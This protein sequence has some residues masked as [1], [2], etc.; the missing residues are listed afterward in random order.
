ML[1]YNGSDR[2]KGSVSSSKGNQLKYNVDDKWIKVDFLGYEGA[3]ELL[4]SEI[5]K[6]SNVS[7]FVEYDLETIKYNNREFTGC[8]SKSFLSGD[9]NVVTLENLILKTCG[10][11]FTS[12]CNEKTTREKI[13]SLVDLVKE[14]TGLEYFGEY[15]TTLLELDAFV[16]NE[17]RHSYNI[18]FL[19]DKGDWSYCPIFDNGAAFLSDMREDYPLEKNYIGLMASV[20]AKPFTKDF[21]SQMELCRELYGEQLQILKS[22]TLENA[23]DKIANFYGE[24]VLERMKLIFEKQKFQ[25]MEMFVDRLRE[26]DWEENLSKIR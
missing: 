11:T 26:P 1:I 3:A 4:C 23:Y 2:K 6:Y 9:E 18:A 15:L 13:V 25:Y 7:Y 17:D 22:I 12:F 8:I 5:L 24:K 20:T 10:C 16:L 19:Y 21:D 14:K